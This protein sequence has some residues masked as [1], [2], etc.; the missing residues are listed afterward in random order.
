MEK[1]RGKG[2]EG[3]GKVK[4]NGKGKVPGSCHFSPYTYK[5]ANKYNLSF[6]YFL[7]N[8]NLW[9]V[10]QLFSTAIFLLTEWVGTIPT[11][12]MI[13]TENSIPESDLDT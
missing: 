7:P 6:R 9:V 2:R 3:K 5:E 13:Q 4:G 1:G 10:F 11:A 8:L 12:T